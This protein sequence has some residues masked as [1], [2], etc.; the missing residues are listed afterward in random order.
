MRNLLFFF[1]FIFT[2]G[3]ILAQCPGPAQRNALINLQRAIEVEGTR[4]GQIPLTDT[5]GN[6]RY[7]QY[8]E[9]NPDTIDYIPADSG[10]TQNLSEFVRDTLGQLWYIDW[11]GNAVQFQGGGG[12]CD[13]D[14]LEISDNS[15]PDAL[16]DSIY[17]YKYVAIGARYVFPGA[18]LLVNDSSSTG[19]AV[20]QGFRNSR[21]ALWDSNSG[22]FIML[23]EAGGAPVFYLPVGA[24]LTFKTTGGTPQTPVGSQ[25]NHFGINTSDSTIQMQQ[26]PNTRRDT[27]AV[28]NFLYT[29]ATGK[30]RSQSPDSIPG[31]GANIYNSN[32]SFPPGSRNAQLDALTDILFRY[33]NLTPLLE[34]YGGD[35]GAATNGY[36][37]IASPD[38]NTYIQVQNGAAFIRSNIG[39]TININADNKFLQMQGSTIAL[40][41]Q[42]D[43]NQFAAVS[44]DTVG[45]NAFLVSVLNTQSSV[46]FDRNIGDGVGFTINN[47]NPTQGQI[48]KARSN[49]LMYFADSTEVGV[50]I[51]NSDGT[52]PASTARHVFID[53][54]SDLFFHY[55]N[56][57]QA[58]RVYSGD[59]PIS[60]ANSYAQINSH[61]ANNVLKV[62]DEAGIDMLF[63]PLSS[64]NHFYVHNADESTFFDFTDAEAQI[65][66]TDSGTGN[67]YRLNLDAPDGSVTWGVN[68]VTGRQASIEIFQNDV[69]S[70]VSSRF[71][72]SAFDPAATD[73]TLCELTGDTAGLVF[74]TR[75]D[76]GTSGD[77]LQPTADGHTFWAGKE[78]NTL[79][80]GN[81][82]SYA[83]GAE[84]AKYI[85]VTANR[86]THV[87][88]HGTI[89]PGESITYITV[90]T[91]NTVSSTVNLNYTP[92]SRYDGNYT[93]MRH[94]SNFG[95][96]TVTVQTNQSWQFMTLA[97]SVTTLTIL[98][99][100]TWE[101]T[102]LADATPANARFYA[103]K[104]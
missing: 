61:S 11:Q 62:D 81:Q 88:A 95:A 79:F 44:L 84:G 14:W 38:N 8:V 40:Q 18:E 71:R 67:H 41:T 43:G 33:P 4:A 64:V 10:N 98:S 34:L 97:G 6:Q 85:S 75:G 53:T 3:N 70:G 29:D 45:S 25:V 35:D 82:L 12:S 66:S 13:T 56:G 80:Q 72:M 46:G 32:G 78:G 17:K 76:V 99:G 30:I 57:T 2:A 93:T 20:I 104:L 100:E 91:A 74:N 31:F 1:I 52:I 77:L 65:E 27:A 96:G 69:I 51:Y 90:D 7:A 47:Q 16:T 36:G 37:K 21:I 83:P 9:V 24:D 103:I 63:G 102:W 23:D 87:V 28:L 94:I 5:C 15:C 26:Y 59:D 60:A 50:N 49:G 92:D 89:T 58:L 48:L 54:L 19:L 73:F 39:G 101:L 68:D 55:A 22:K 42:I 86:F